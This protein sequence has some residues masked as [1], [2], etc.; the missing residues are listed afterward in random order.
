LPRVSHAAPHSPC[1]ARCMEAQAQPSREATTACQEYRRSW[2]GF[3]MGLCR[4]AWCMQRCTLST[5]LLTSLCPP[6]P[7]G[8]APRMARPKWIWDPLLSGDA[9]SRS[10]SSAGWVARQRSS[11]QLALLR[12]LAVYAPLVASIRQSS[13]E[14][15]YTT[16]T[17]QETCSQPCSITAPFGCRVRHCV[18]GNEAPHLMLLQTPRSLEDIKCLVGPGSV[19]FLSSSD[20][21]TTTKQPIHQKPLASSKTPSFSKH[22]RFSKQ[23]Q[24]NQ[25]KS[26]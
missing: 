18:A 14:S 4:L 3:A 26:K 17:V 1:F 13:A 6:I 20:S 12:L 2:H 16:C 24:H 25:P 23:P 21:L 22:L 5:V 7:R 10:A 9:H 11:L 15:C 19:S 8:R